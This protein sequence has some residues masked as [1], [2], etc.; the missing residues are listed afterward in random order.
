MAQNRLASFE[1]PDEHMRGWGV[2][3][4]A[5]LS[6]HVG[7]EN[8]AASQQMCLRVGFGAGFA[9]GHDVAWTVPELSRKDGGESGGESVVLQVAVGWRVA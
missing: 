2:N 6:V 7:V 9:A 5:E 1:Q 8:H 3:S 4:F